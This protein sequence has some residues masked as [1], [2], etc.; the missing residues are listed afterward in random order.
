MKKSELL[1]ARKQWSGFT[2]IEMSIVMFIISLLIL[3]ILP[4]IGK[5]RD[6]ARGVGNQALGDVVQTQADLYRNETDKEVVTLE[7]LKGS[8]YLNEKQYNEAKKAK[9]KVEVEK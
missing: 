8:G 3:I 1:G 2:L 9:I 5:Q 4:N 7:D 6:N